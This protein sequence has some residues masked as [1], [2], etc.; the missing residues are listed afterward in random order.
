MAKPVDDT[1]SI[2]DF[3]LVCILE[4]ETGKRNHS[5]INFIS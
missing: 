4:T 3:N 5:V 1:N 2:D